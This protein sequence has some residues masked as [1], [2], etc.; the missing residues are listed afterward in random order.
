VRVSGRGDCVR[1]FCARRPRNFDP[2][3]FVPAD[4]DR[5]VS[6]CRVPKRE[7]VIVRASAPGLATEMRLVSHAQVLEVLDLSCRLA[8][9]A[10]DIA[11][12]FARAFGVQQRNETAGEG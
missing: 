4:S 2:R 5:S 12:A 11:D 7:M 1:G 8:L 10:G 9:V 3:A 6:L